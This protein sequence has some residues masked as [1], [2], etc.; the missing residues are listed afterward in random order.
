MKLFGFN[1]SLTRNQK[2]QIDGQTGSVQKSFDA[3]AWLAGKDY[4][5]V[6]TRLENPFHRVAWLYRAAT[7][8]AEQ[9][10]N[11][12]FLF[13][14]GERG[15]EHL[16]TSGPLHD[17]YNKPHPHINRF[18][19]WELRVLSLLL[20]GECFR[21]PI[22]Q[23]DHPP[24]GAAMASPA[25]TVPTSPIKNQKSKIKNVLILNPDHFQEI[26]Q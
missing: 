6:R 5:P 24:F 11:T 22:Y 7:V 17:F 3:A 20:R 2:S 4:E 9:I 23:E 16:I 21:I 14:R 13:S 26:I 18:E 19:Y 15:R 8:L 1:L 25:R 10:A 12:P